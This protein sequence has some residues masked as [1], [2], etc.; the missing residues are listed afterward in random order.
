MV[1]FLP[2]LE[3]KEKDP[4]TKENIKLLNHK[5][6]T[7][8]N[9]V[10]KTLQFETIYKSSEVLDFE[11]INLREEIQ[12]CIENQLTICDNKEINI[13]NKINENIVVKADKLYLKEVIINLLSN[14]IKNI[15]DAGIITVDAYKEKDV[16]TISVED[17]G[18][19]IDKGQ[20]DH[21]FE[22]FYKTDISR[23]DLD[24]SGL[25]LSICKQIVEKHG[26][27]IWAESKGFGKG[28]TFFFTLKSSF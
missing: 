17:N 23:H 15:H 28:S 3:K 27:Q 14:A 4:K 1:A 10:E 5:V 20:L 18:L 8:K 24:S 7:L 25:G 22:E 6:N 11:N 2:I 21:I 13:D 16:V 9:L 26:G 19:G 12:D